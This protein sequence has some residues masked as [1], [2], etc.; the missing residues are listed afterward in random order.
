[1]TS[2]LIWE[3]TLSLLWLVKVKTIHWGPRDSDTFWMKKAWKS[4]TR[5]CNVQRSLARSSERLKT[6]DRPKKKQQKTTR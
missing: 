6:M 4:L 2:S 5:L 1:M 3:E